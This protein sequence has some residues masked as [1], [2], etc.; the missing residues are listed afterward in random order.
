MLAQ[1]DSS[2]T[3]V[4]DG[5]TNSGAVGIVGNF[6]VGNNTTLDLLGNILNSGTI[7]ALGNVSIDGHVYLYGNGSLSLNG[8]TIDGSNAS[9]DTLENHNVIQGYGF[10]GAGH[11]S[12]DNF[13]TID[14]ADPGHLMTIDTGSTGTFVNAGLIKSDGYGIEIVHNV[15]N[16]GVFES[17]AQDGLIKV[18]GDYSGSGTVTLDGGNVAFEHSSNA[19][20]K[21]SG[22]GGDTLFLDDVKDFKGSVAGFGD[23]DLMYLANTNASSVHVIDDHG[24]TE[25]Q[26]LHGSGK[27]QTFVLHGN[28]D[29]DDFTIA[30]DGDGTGTDIS[31]HHPAPTIVTDSFTVSQ[32]GDIATVHGLYVEDDDATS[33]RVSVT[34]GDAP[35]SSVTP[36]QA[37][38]DLDDI[39]DALSSIVYNPGANPPQQDQVNVKVTDNFGD[40]STVHFV[41]DQAGQGPNISLTGTTGNDVII[42]TGEPDML[43]GNGGQDQ[44]VFKPSNPGNTGTVEHT[45]TD[46]NASLDTIDLRQFNNISSAAA[47]ISTAATH[48]SDTLL[49]LDNHETLLLKNVAVS[50]LHAS[51][52]IVSP[53]SST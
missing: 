8:S 26:I 43:T 11:L 52:F 51:D 36:S 16:N 35:E 34:T 4:L 46:F 50:S 38:G 47:V 1:G 29:P 42:A 31:L 44:F 13:G 24:T 48:G 41:F 9:V 6:L 7:D 3:T 33:F 2:T 18:D 20:V 45:I 21:F 49:T 23:G 14:A 25:V 17:S 40:S 19:T 10:V 27:A 39:N 5:S 53:H 37:S 30:Q 28:Y 12:L 22:N 32:S 15:V